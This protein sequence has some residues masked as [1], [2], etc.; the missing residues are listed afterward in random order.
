MTELTEE[1]VSIRSTTIVK[2]IDA[3]QKTID[4]Y[5]N[6]S[7][8]IGRRQLEERGYRITTKD[9]DKNLARYELISE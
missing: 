3:G 1:N 9:L 6:A 8:V 7:S 2:Q 5:L 4:V